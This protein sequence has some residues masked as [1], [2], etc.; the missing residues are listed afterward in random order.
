MEVE[1]Q[2]FVAHEKEYEEKHR[3]TARDRT[4]TA[5]MDQCLNES[6]N[7]KVEI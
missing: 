6:D 1:D 2:E 3:W 4:I 7:R 5:K